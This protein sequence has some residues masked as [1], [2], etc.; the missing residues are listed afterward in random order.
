MM[1]TGFFIVKDGVFQAMGDAYK[2]E[3]ILRKWGLYDVVFK[4]TGWI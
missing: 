2:P 4:H 3:E 1:I